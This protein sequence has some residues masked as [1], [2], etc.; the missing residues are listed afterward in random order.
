MTSEQINKLFQAF[1]QADAST[2]R[3]YGGTG[4]GLAITKKFTEMMGGNI[5]VESEFGK[6]STFTV[7]L[8]VYIEVTETKLPGKTP[9]SPLALQ[10][11]KRE[12]NGIILIIDDDMVVRDLLCGYL[13]KIGYQVA[14]AGGGEEG[15]RLA[16]KL[17]PHAITLDVMMPDM[18][19]WSVLSQLKADAELSDIP[20]IVLSIIEEKDRGYSLGA[21]EYLLKPIT[22][23]QLATV[24]R[25]YESGKRPCVMIVDDDQVTRNMVAEM[26]EQLGCKIITVEN[27]REGLACLEVEQPDLILLDLMMPEMNGFEFAMH[28][29]DHEMWKSIPIVVLTAKEIT[30]EDRA[31]LNGCVET[32][33]Q[34]GAY[35]RDE[36][37]SEVHSL[38]KL[39][40]STKQRASA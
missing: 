6:G 24:L 17:H 32:I 26:L 19:G 29:H 28:L 12:E 37:L 27:G 4:L 16:K 14:T 33:F 18:D 38:V 22:R 40:A 23:K 11:L 36:L 8:P 25:K 9:L 35:T 15:L 10:K 7:Y 1:T 2:T 31:Q 30:A 5:E 20:V 39:A 34:K 21:A 3:K 13:S